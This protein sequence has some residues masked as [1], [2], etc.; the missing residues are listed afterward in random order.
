MHIRQFVPKIIRQQ[1][2][3]YQRKRADRRSGDAQRFARQAPSLPPMSY[4]IPLV[5]EIKL[6]YL[7]ENKI[8]NIK[9]SSEKVSEVVIHSNEIFSFWETIGIPNAQNGYLKGRNIIAGK[10]G[11]DYGGGL[12]QVSSILYHLALQAGMTIVERHNHSVDIYTPETRFT[13]LGSDATVA[14]GYKDLRLL[15]PFPFPLRFD[16]QVI[17][18]QFHAALWSEKP[19]PHH[20]IVFEVIKRGSQLEVL[21]M[22]E[23]GITVGRSC[24]FKGE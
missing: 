9:R 20:K 16:L 19:V 7:Y 23:A 15:N 10:L 13:P 2:R 4:A 12:C 11:E 14:Y 18:Y 1:I 6:S 3:L 22:N 21:A 5:Q 24:Y 8:A 17:G